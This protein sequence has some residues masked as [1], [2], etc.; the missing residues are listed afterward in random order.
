MSKP[1]LEITISYT[2]DGRQFSITK[3][4]YAPKAPSD[5]TSAQFFAE[6]R[7]IECIREI[8]A[9]IAPRLPAEQDE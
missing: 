8:L 3:R 1:E 6:A 9:C 7:A 4:L 2:G 5:I